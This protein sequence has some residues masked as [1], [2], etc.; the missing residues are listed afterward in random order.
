[1]SNFPKEIISEKCR[2]S[3]CLRDTSPWFSERTKACNEEAGRYNKT[4]CADSFSP[5][6]FYRPVERFCR[7]DRQGQ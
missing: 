3:T 4:L 1:M 5:A 2:R 7:Q 6:K